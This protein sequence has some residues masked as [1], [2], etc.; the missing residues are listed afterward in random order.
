[1]TV[2][3]M[4]DGVEVAQASC[5]EAALVLFDNGKFSPK[6]GEKVF[7][8]SDERGRREIYLH[9]IKWRNSSQIKWKNVP[10]VK[11]RNL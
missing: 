7:A 5:L 8:P 3:F 2:F 10:P 9:F 11:W 1:M 4:K 6:V